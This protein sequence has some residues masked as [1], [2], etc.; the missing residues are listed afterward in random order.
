MTVQLSPLIKALR[1]SASGIHA[2]N[3]RLLVISQNLAHAGMRTSP[4]SSPYQRQVIA[5]TSQLDKKSG[6][7]MI[8]IKGVRNDKTPFERIYAPED[9]VADESGYVLESN[10]K[11]PSEMID[12]REASRSHESSVRAFEKTLA[13]FQNTIS[14]LKN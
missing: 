6:A 14:L 10:V 13:M 12:L 1:V 8:H 7:Y 5:L 3:Q 9:P 4:Q 2:Q 11:A